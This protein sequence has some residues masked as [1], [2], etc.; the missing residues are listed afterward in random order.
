MTDGELEQL[1]QQADGL[2]RDA[3]LAL[4]GECRKRNIMADIVS[5]KENSLINANIERIRENISKEEKKW[6]N[7]VLSYAFEQKFNNASNDAILAGLLGMKASLDE[8][9]YIENN[10]EKLAGERLNQ[11]ATDRIGGIIKTIGG[12]AI[13]TIVFL[14][15][16]GNNAMIFGGIIMV[17]GLVEI[18]N[19]ASRKSRYETIIQNIENQTEEPHGDSRD[20]SEDRLIG[21]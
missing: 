19:A 11:A 13:I 18:A 10:L 6:W 15:S 20:A 17:F 9:L 21:H 4:K 1:L 2:R 7:G 3:F 12:M 16:L 14:A 5:E 8:A